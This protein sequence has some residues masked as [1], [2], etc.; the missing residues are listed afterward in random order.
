VRFRAPTL[1]VGAVGVASILTACGS[2]STS[3]TT[4]PLAQTPTTAPTPSPTAD[5]TALGQEFLSLEAPYHAAFVTLNNHMDAGVASNK[6]LAACTAP[7]ATAL[8]QFDSSLLQLPWPN[9]VL[10]DAHALVTAHGVV[11]GDLENA[12]NETDFTAWLS[13]FQADY[14]KTGSASQILLADL[15]L[16]ALPPLPAP[17]PNHHPC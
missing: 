1:L 4:T 12:Q 10:P 9:Q 7:V 17:I 13:Q 3:A 14:S 15:H 11:L 8:Q 2:G 16:P 6:A 5:L